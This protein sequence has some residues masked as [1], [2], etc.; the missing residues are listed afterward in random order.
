M[1]KLRNRILAVLCLLAFAGVGVLYFRGWVVQKPFGIILFVGDGLAGS[2]LAAARLYKDGA[3]TRLF[4]E[5]FPN[6]AMLS[7]YGR[8]FAVADA[9]AAATLLATGQRPGGR[10]LGLGT[11]GGEIATLLDLARS[12]GRTTGLVTNARI[13]DPAL[14]AF[15]GRVTRATERELLAAQIVDRARPDVMM[16]G[17]LSDFVP[18]HKGGIRGDGRDLWI[19][20][21]DAGFDTPRTRAEL[22]SIPVWKVPK[23]FGLFSP[24]DLP[25]AGSAAADAPSLS[26]MVRAAIA[27]L[28]FN[29]AGYLLIVDAGL[30]ARAS[31]SNL[32][33]NTLREIAELDRAIETAANYA[34]GNALIL[35]TAKHVT[36]G[37]VMNGYPLRE[38]RGMAVVGRNARGIPSLTWSTGPGSPQDNP[39]PDEPVASPMET[40]AD[41]VEDPVAVGTGMGSER[42]RGFQDASLL[43][44]I[45]RDEL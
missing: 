37:F 20:L 3:T 43:F 28:Q 6:M 42:L 35:A 15:Y 31:E 38:D 34:G 19:E 8:E 45:I 21:R 12:A 26:D 24:D 11:D 9:S 32:G 1:N 44:E 7:N 40:A 13:T 30:I 29:R 41:T 39:Q 17:G 27:R 14:A 18:S 2:R 16:G 23:I 10:G 5:S 36:G 4:L 33:E 22:E 25:Y